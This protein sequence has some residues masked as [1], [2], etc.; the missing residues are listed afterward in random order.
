M[1]QVQN[2]PML[3]EN[4]PVVTPTTNDS[5]MSLAEP[6]DIPGESTAPVQPESF[7]ETQTSTESPQT[8]SPAQ[9]EAG[10]ESSSV[11]YGSGSDSDSDS[12]SESGDES[13]SE[14][15]S[16]AGP[17]APWESSTDLPSRENLSVVQRAQVNQKQDSQKPE[18]ASEEPGTASPS[19]GNQVKK[20]AT[21]CN[22][23]KTETQ[24]PKKREH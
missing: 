14:M 18:T 9:G 4:C 7:M 5:S 1:L 10:K 11:D 24:V 12:S 15:E 16:S 8:P 22:S 6:S 20:K 3:G 21:S 23:G 2:S 17:V 19:K 13:G